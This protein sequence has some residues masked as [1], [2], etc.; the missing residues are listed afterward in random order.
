[1]GPKFCPIREYAGGFDDDVNPE[2]FPRQPPRIELIE[3][4]HFPAVDLKHSLADF[5][6]SG[7]NPIVRIVTEQVRIGMQIGHVIDR[8]D[9]QIVFVARQHRPQG[10]PSYSAETVNAYSRTHSTSL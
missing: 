5:H 6:S 3:D 7:K 4:G 9:I 10:Q 2:L 1:M 8:D